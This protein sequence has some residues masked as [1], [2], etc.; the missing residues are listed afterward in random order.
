[1]KKIETQ[2]CAGEEIL[3]IPVTYSGGES[4]ESSSRACDFMQAFVYHNGEEAEM[5]AERLLPSDIEVLEMYRKEFG[6]DEDEVDMADSEEWFVE[7]KLTDY[8][9]R[10][11]PELIADMKTQAVELGIDPNRLVY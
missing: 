6:L 9:E 11:Y 4:R 8:S 1:M 5:Y 2:I 7:N 3:D 10:L